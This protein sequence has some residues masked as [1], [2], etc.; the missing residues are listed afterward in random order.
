MD[1]PLISAQALRALLRRGH[2]LVVLDASFDLGDPAA[3]E[4]LYRE[5]HVPGARYVHL[6]RDLVGAKSG[7]NGRH[8]LPTREAF[9]VTAGRLGI[10]P[11]TPVVVYDRQQ[12]A[13]AARAWWMLRWLGHDEVAVLDGGWSAWQAAGGQSDSAVPTVDLA[14]PYPQASPL[15]AAIDAAG[16]AAQL[17]RVRLVDARAPERFRGEI[18]PLDKEPGHIPGATNRFFQDN[19]AADGRFKPADQLRAE[20]EPLAPEPAGQVVHYCG[21]GVTACHNVLAMA[22]AGLGI[23]M[24]YPGSW[25]EWSADSARPIAKG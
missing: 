8:P 24:L 5:A 2:R 4:R 16:M 6:D 10:T 19:L 15:V 13:Y 12:G 22:I 1:K 11:E 3:G 14:P 20:L 7:A 21:S 25:S 17:G 18:E 23:G 9:A